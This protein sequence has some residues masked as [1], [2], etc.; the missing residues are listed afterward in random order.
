MTEKLSTTIKS[1]SLVLF[2]QD[3]P[4]HT[5][6]SKLAKKAFSSAE[7]RR[8]EEQ[9]A[10]MTTSLEINKGIICDLLQSKTL[11]QVEG[12]LIPKLNDENILL[13]LRLKQCYSELE[14]GSA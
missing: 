10:D 14:E 7:Q 6:P 13:R 11:H 8:L 1:G 4:L 3:P 12:A 9:L 5:E 2:T